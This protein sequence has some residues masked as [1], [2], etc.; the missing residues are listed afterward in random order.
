[1]RYDAPAGHGRDCLKLLASRLMRAMM[2]LT[3]SSP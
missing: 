1:M 3:D 2:T